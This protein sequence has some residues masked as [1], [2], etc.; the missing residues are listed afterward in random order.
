MGCFDD[1]CIVCG[2]PPRSPFDVTIKQY[3]INPRT[4]AWMD[5]CTMLLNNGSVIHNAEKRYMCSRF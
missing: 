3:R 5:K 2:L 1:H 4:V